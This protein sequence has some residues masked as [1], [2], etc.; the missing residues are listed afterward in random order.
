MLRKSVIHL[1]HSKDS[2]SLS[3]FFLVSKKDGGGGEARYQS[4]GIT[5]IH[6]LF[7]LQNGRFASAK[8]H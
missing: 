8:R 5:F 6:P 7:L 4:E 3:N 2:Q 1:I